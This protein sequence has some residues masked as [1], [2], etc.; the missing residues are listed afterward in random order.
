MKIEN[1]KKNLTKIYNNLRKL[2]SKKNATIKIFKVKKLESQIKNYTFDFSF[3]RI[4]NN[5]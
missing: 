5:L 1:R 2:Q 3:I 4:F